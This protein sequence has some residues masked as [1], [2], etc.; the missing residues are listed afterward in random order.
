M[1][2]YLAA[3]FE[4]SAQVIA[5][6]CSGHSFSESRVAVSVGVS[7]LSEAAIVGVDAYGEDRAVIRIC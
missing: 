5:M 3:R 7:L 2:E 6:G 4:G 1:T